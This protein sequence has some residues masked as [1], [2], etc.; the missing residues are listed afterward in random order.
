MIIEKVIVIIAV[1]VLIVISYI[2]SFLFFSAILYTNSQED[3]SLKDKEQ[4][5]YLKAWSKTHKTKDNKNRRNN[6][7]RKSN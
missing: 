3:E 4:E 7:T 6:D 1:I 2:A 5:E